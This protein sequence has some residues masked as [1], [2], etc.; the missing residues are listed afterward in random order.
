MKKILQKA[1]DGAID[2]PPLGEVIFAGDSVVIAPDS[3]VVEQGQLLSALVEY[4]LG[5][6]CG[7]DDLTILLTAGEY[8]RETR[9]GRLRAL[10]PE[11]IRGADIFEGFYPARPNACAVLA[12]DEEG[13]PIKMARTLVE[14]DVV[15]PI[16][17]YYPDPPLGHYGL[18][19]A[20]VPRF[21]DSEVQLRFQS[22][23]SE[24][25]RQKI[26]ETFAPVVTDLAY[27]L[28]AGM[29]IEVIIG[30]SDQIDSAVFG[31]IDALRERYAPKL[32]AGE[33]R[34]AAENRNTK[35]QDDTKEQNDTG[36]Q[37]STG[38]RK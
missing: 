16:E 27:R 6:G 23:D 15:I 29:A 28:G 9:S 26:I 11:S 2:F 30:D 37:D 4:L 19:S 10:L 36:E 17:R 7:A 35:E 31:R 21:A 3:Y 13:N 33:N 22:A 20:L 12:Q 8:E 1:F 25:K 24:T 34:N 32:A 14:A 18:L 5:T 38:E